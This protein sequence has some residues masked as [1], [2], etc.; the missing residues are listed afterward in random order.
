LVVKFEDDG[1]LKKGVDLKTISGSFHLR[2]DEPDAGEAERKKL[3]ASA[4]E[5]TT[6][7]RV[8]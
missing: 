8:R 5:T 2:A 1:V 3:F 7:K 4:L 6:P